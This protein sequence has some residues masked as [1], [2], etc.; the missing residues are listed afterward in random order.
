MAK[1]AGEIGKYLHP[2]AYGQ[3]ES[4]G[5]DYEKRQSLERQGPEAGK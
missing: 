4:M 3:P 1:P 2:E 5:V